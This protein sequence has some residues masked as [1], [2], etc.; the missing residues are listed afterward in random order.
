MNKV[1]NQHYLSRC[2]SKNF[3]T[4]KNNT[5]YEYDC[6]DNNPDKKIRE[7]NINKL[8]SARR[9]WGQN[10][11]KKLSEEF[12]NKLAKILKKYANIKINRFRAPLNTHVK[13][14][15]FNALVIDNEEDKNVLSKL[16]IQQIMLQKKNSNVID[17]EQEKNLSYFLE[18]PGGLEGNITLVEIHPSIPIP[19]ILIDA[20]LFFYFIPNSDNTD[21]WGHIQFMFPISTSRFLLW[22]NKKDVEYFCYKYQNIHYLNLCRVAQQEKKCRIATQNKEY[23]EL[24]IKQINTLYF[25]NTQVNIASVRNI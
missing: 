23:L 1:K 6:G 17:D 22:G 24:L 2:I 20:M 15:E 11:E 12:E 4:T 8:F 19:L 16:L 9:I 21:N 7:K 3:V 18:Y 14:K 25:D 10:I 13:E 5:F